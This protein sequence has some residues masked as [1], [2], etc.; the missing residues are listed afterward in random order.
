ME[1]KGFN[2]LYQISDDGTKVL[3]KG[4]WVTQK[5]QYG[6]YKRYMK[7]KECKVNIDNEGYYSVTLNGTRIR[8]HRI[9]YETFIG[10]IPD[11]YVI[12]HKNGNRLDNSLDN[13]R[14]VPQ[15]LNSRNTVLAKR[16]DIRKRGNKHFLRFSSDGDRKYY[17]MFNSYDE[18]EKKYNELYVQRQNHYTETGLFF[19]RG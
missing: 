13:L 18:A 9:L 5:N 7:P 10:D 3:R 17:G 11:G 8:L 19:E 4:Y 14:A 2:G 6:E 12:D 15:N 16:P 1:I